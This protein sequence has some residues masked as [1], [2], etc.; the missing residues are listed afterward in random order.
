MRT[1]EK[2]KGMQTSDILFLT[3]LALL[4]VAAARER[5]VLAAATIVLVGA[6]AVFKVTPNGRYIYAALPLLSV[7]FAALSS[8]FAVGANSITTRSSPWTSA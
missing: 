3:P 7:P 6:I 1:I 4:G 8:R 5:R 2:R